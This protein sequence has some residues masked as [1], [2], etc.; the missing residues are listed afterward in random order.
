MHVG[1][2]QLFALEWEITQIVD[3]WIF[4]E[5]FFWIRGHRIGNS[6]DNS[7]H[8][9]GVAEWIANF[10]EDPQDRFEPELFDLS[11]LEVYRRLALSVLVQ[12]DP[13][14]ESVEVYKNTFSRFHISHIG[15]SSF[16]LTTLLLKDS[17]GLERCVW[18]VYQGEICDAYLPENEMENVFRQ[19]LS[20]F[21]NNWR[22][23][24][25]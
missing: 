16:D 1:D 22:I 20:V 13:E 24:A 11:K 14:I 3:N 2:K 12:D 19:F 8:L 7:V 18:K 23:T 25:N 21:E 15:M 17:S 6:S 10:L 4:G 9:G 5:F